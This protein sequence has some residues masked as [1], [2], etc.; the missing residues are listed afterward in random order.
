V[1]GEAPS[2]LI[3]NQ[4][5]EGRRSLH[6]VRLRVFDLPLRDRHAADRSLKSPVELDGWTWFPPACDPEKVVMLSDTGMLGLFGIKQANNRD[7]ALFPL[8]PGGGL[9][10]KEL[11]QAAPGRGDRAQVVQVQGD[12]LWV[13]AAGQ[14]QRL[15]LAW[16]L[17]DGP[18]VVPV[19]QQSQALKE[20]GSPQHACQVADDRRTGGRCLY[21]VTRPARRQTYLATAVDDETGNVRWQRQLGLVCEGE[22][23]SLAVDGGG[24]PVLLA[25][26]SGG[27]LYLLDPTRLKVIEGQRWVR[28]N[29]SVRLAE[30]LTD[31]PDERPMLLWAQDGK[32]VYQVLNPGKGNELVVRHVQPAAGGRN[33]QVTEQTVDL[34]SALAGAP[35][36]LGPRLL[37]PLANGT[38]ARLPL[39]LA[40]NAE[41][42]EGPDWRAVRASP[43]ARCQIL[44][45]GGDRFLTSDGARG[46]TCWEWPVGQNCRALPG[47][48][49]PTLQMND[50]VVA[51]LLVGPVKA[52]GLARVC[53]ADSAGNLTLMTV[54]GD[55]SLEKERTW[56]LG[57][58]VT[59]GPFLRRLPD[60]AVRVGCIVDGSRLAWLDPQRDGLAWQF[61]TPRGDPIVGEPRL[62]GNLVVVADQSGRFVGLN[63]AT[64]RPAGPGHR[65]RGSVVP[66][67]AP[68][69]FGPDRLL[70]PLSDGTLLLLAKE[71]V[72]HPL[73]WFPSGW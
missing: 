8:L 73:R 67:S 24:P 59:A 21:L 16:G 49:V 27:G 31:N 60:G 54:Q 42:E 10:L 65:L 2:Y 71:R 63:P 35:A 64:G 43:D 28:D 23:V 29:Q 62:A 4:K 20:L 26:D 7:Q 19:W 44:P 38:L 3:L 61:K 11:L 52:G 15:R 68:V 53:L 36:V 40:A 56:A 32:A 37:L 14:L 34:K 25:Q 9:D 18:Q 45:L 41:V 70:A 12:D 72:Q 1:G 5:S 55:G 69:P 48:E 47:G 22:P 50:R 66:V 30:S 58:E 6:A 46:V 57:G 13:L 51:G 33:L 17:A 39:P